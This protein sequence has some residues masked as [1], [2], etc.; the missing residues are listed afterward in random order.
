MEFNHIYLV[1]N[2]WEISE[3]QHIMTVCKVSI[4]LKNENLKN[5]WQN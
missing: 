4:K 5:Q 3:K 2:C 1:F